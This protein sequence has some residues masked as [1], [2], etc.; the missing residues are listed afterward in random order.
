MPWCPST[1]FFKEEIVPIPPCLLDQ[2]ICLLWQEVTVVAAVVLLMSEFVT[3]VLTI[4]LI[5]TL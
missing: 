1:L 2:A 4:L 3:L 5:P